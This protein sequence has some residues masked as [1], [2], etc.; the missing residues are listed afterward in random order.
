MAGFPGEQRRVYW[1][2]GRDRSVCSRPD[3]V[4]LMWGGSGTVPLLLISFWKGLFFP[5]KLQNLDH[6][7]LMIDANSCL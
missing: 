4:G 7:G 1:V 2:G 6:P 5:R 3:A